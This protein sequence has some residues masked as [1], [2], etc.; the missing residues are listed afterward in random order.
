MRR[1][2]L[3]QRFVASESAGG[4]LLAAAAAFAFVWANTPFAPAYF[5][6][7]ELA[8]PLGHPSLARSLEFWVNDGLMVIFFLL[9]GLEI[10]REVLV[11]ELGGLRRAMLPVVAA[12]G[13][14]VCPAA[15]YAAANW[16]TEGI[17]G[18]GIPMATDIAFALGVLSLLGRGVP[19]SLKVF[20]TALAIIDDLG[21]VLVIALFY[22]E[23][24]RLVGVGLSVL[25]VVAC[26]AYGRLGGRRLSVFAALG[27]VL[28]YFVLTSGVHPT[29][30][31]VL[32]AMTIPLTADSPLHRLEHG[33]APWVSY[34]ILPVFA[35][36]NAGVTL[37]GDAAVVS[38][39]TAG[40]AL[41]LFVGKPLGIAGFSWLAA[42]AGVVCLP[43][44]AGWRSMIGIGLLGGIGFTMS[45]F[46]NTLAFPHSPLL[47]QAKVGVLATSAIAAAAGLLVL[48]SS[49]GRGHPG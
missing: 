25:V 3:F 24:L 2:N 27:V 17:R 10:K 38:G 35:L 15:I 12:I 13:G 6:M 19:A 23:K 49:S 28:W 14:M 42:R 11:G 9:V 30:A 16:G 44:G 46:I 1:L 5:H 47:D 29:V 22:S 18:W 48:R 26:F 41:G 45:L 34:A 21:A 7:K 40:V 36:M 4:I 31:G 33:L 39:V 8:L 32:L 37:R 20:L 43:N